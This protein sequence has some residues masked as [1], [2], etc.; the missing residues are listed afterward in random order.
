M[1]DR[2]QQRL[3]REEGFTLI[4]LLVVIVII[5]ILLAIAVPSYLGFRDRATDAAAGE[6]PRGRPVGRGVLR[7]QH[8][9][10]RHPTSTEAHVCATG[11][12]QHTYDSRPQGHDAGIKI[13][14]VT[15]AATYAWRLLL[16]GRSAGTSA[17]RTVPFDRSHG[18]E[19]ATRRLLV[20]QLEPL[21]AATEGRGHPRPSS[22]V[23]RA[24]DREGQ[25]A[26]R[27][28]PRRQMTTSANR[29]PKFER[30]PAA[31]GPGGDRS[32][33]GR[34]SSSAGLWGALARN[35]GSAGLSAYEASRE[36]GSSRRAS[37]SRW[38]ALPCASRRLRMRES[39][40]EACSRRLGVRNLRPM[41]HRADGAGDDARTRRF[42][43]DRHA[44]LVPS[45]P[46]PTRSPVDPATRG[47]EPGFG[48]RRRPRRTRR[49]STPRSPTLCRGARRARRGPTGPVEKLALAA[50]AAAARASASR[51]ARSSCCAS[52]ATAAGSS[53][54]GAT[55]SHASRRPR[56]PTASPASA[57]T[58][59][60]TRTSSAS[61]RAAPAPAR[62]S[63]SSCST[64]TA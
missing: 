2:L 51:A 42:V 56:S 47:S 21:T 28:S 14:G 46:S 32:R 62:S 45:R 10:Q 9:L 55:S 35:A 30:F 11:N 54:R 38:N 33:R 5:G 37:R 53:A 16:P 19:V 27:G 7:R 18:G 13:H 34:S 41:S 60:S 44:L 64:S 63:A 40:W 57:T 24:I 26:R 52:S 36:R 22:L 50:I 59:P 15:L 17:P 23:A 58:A 48:E 49:I 1:L 43:R 25:T 3:A 20:K 31:P 4:E 29:K 8:E 61:S 12:G 6:R 39:T